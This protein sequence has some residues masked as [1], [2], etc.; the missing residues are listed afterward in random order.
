MMSFLDPASAVKRVRD[1]NCVIAPAR[2]KLQARAA[3]P[4]RR[5]ASAIREPFMSATAL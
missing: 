3:G 1:H 5:D 4:H 2:G